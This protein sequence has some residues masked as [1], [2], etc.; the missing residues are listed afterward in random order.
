[1]QTVTQLFRLDGRTALI[2]GGSRGLGEEIAHG[3]AESGASVYIVARREKWLT[4]AIE[5]LR[6]AGA[7]CEG[8]TCDV[9]D[10]EQVRQTVRRAA[11]T[12]GPID[13]LV[14]NA[15]AT[16]GAPAEEMPLDKWESVIATNLTGA[17][18]FSQECAQGMIKRR[19]GRII[20][21][22]SIAGLRG[23][24]P[25]GIHCSGYVAAKGG[26]IALTRELACKWAQHN[27]RVNA[28]APGFFPTR[29]TEGIL[30][31]M[32]DD[33]KQNVPMARPGRD[34]EIKGVAVFLASD[35]SGYITGQTLSVD[36]GSTASAI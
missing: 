14:N 25:R 10:Q 29:M 28:I 36:G 21:I 26:L 13:I 17:F 35:A 8:S 15:G 27:I 6:A 23:S 22:A 9:A 11:E 7:R 2:T 20:N 34:G 12:F 30:P 18:L 4:P 5:S 33:I 24:L 16:W 32:M 1:M 31:A 3:M 19:S